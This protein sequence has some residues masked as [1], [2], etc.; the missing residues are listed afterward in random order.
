MEAVYMPIVKC[1]QGELLALR[2]LDK[3]AKSKIL[4]LLEFQ[5][6]P[7]SWTDGTWVYKKTLDVHISDTISDCQRSLPSLPFAF[8]FM[9]FN[10]SVS[11]G[12]TS[13][14]YRFLEASISAGLSFYPV[15]R[16]KS[17]LHFLRV[18][19][20]FSRRDLIPGICLRVEAEFVDSDLAET[21]RNI[22]SYTGVSQNR[23]IVVIDV[24]DVVAS[25]ATM[26]AEFVRYT[27]NLLTKG[28]TWAAVF[29]AGSSAPQSMAGIPV[30]ISSTPRTEW[31]VFK[32]VRSSLSEIPLLYSDY[33]I[34]N[35]NPMP[36]IDP[37]ILF[38][39]AIAKIIYTTANDYIIIR[40]NRVR[41][42][43]YGQ[44]QEMCSS[45]I[46]H[47][48]FA[49]AGFSWGDLKIQDCQAGETSTGNLTTWVQVNTNHHIEH[50]V[51][52]IASM[53]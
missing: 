46:E 30:G 32:I 36:D 43:G 9:H 3:L 24:K 27:I 1:K 37:R 28:D 10:P 47:P 19:S 41:R 42:Y 14:A 38:D 12:G 50:V 39:R 4:P 23:I 33:A 2:R 20:S 16:V 21:I 45:I 17:S 53:F 51:H 52:Q 15:V 29:V 7:K 25:K 35:P 34:G 49:G 8:D 40:G 26:H 13:L 18:L 44:Y 5:D 22:V 11:L 31:E 6:I 48:W